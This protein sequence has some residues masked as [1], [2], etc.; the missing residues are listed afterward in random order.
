MVWPG[1][2]PFTIMEYRIQRNLLVGCCDMGTGD[3]LLRIAGDGE[4]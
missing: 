4:E 2:F 3:E 1:C